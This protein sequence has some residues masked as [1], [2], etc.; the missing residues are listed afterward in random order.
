MGPP[1]ECATCRLGLFSG[2]TLAVAACASHTLPDHYGIAPNGAPIPGYYGKTVQVTTGGLVETIE[3]DEGRPLNL[4]INAV[5]LA[6][7]EV[8]F[9]HELTIGRFSRWLGSGFSRASNV[10]YR[11]RIPDEG[12]DTF[13]IDAITH[14]VRWTVTT[15]DPDPGKVVFEVSIGRGR[16]EAP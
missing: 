14:Y 15:W 12:A 9:P 11:K 10:Y 5:D 1:T 4:Q 6:P 7:A 16:P 3:L 8:G 2:L 13:E